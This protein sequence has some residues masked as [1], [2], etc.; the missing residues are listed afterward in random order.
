MGSIKRG[1]R[2]KLQETAKKNK[3]WSLY[4]L[5]KELGI[6]QQTVYS[7]ASERTMPKK[8]NLKKICEI[9]GCTTLDL[10]GF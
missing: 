6:P 10:Y 7:W 4:R 9:L 8:D 3:N 2:L 1:L 5:A